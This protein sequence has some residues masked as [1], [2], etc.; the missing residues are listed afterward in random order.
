MCG[1][2]SMHSL[3]INA[4]HS[5]HLSIQ[6]DASALH[7]ELTG[8]VYFYDCVWSILR[9]CILFIV[10]FMCQQSVVAVATNTAPSAKRIHFQL[11]IDKGAKSLYIDNHMNEVS[12]AIETHSSGWQTNCKLINEWQVETMRRLRA[13][14]IADKWTPQCIDTK[15]SS[16]G[17]CCPV[18]AII[19]R[20]AVCPCLDLF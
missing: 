1:H 14:P 20:N 8:F 6:Y 16:T 7:T 11:T 2:L 18:I 10:I 13:I 5:I 15:T 19:S 9:D 4:F 17:L 3:C 12:R